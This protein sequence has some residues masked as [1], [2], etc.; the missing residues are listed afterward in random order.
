MLNP[1]YVLRTH[2]NFRDSSGN[3]P[4]KTRS[5]VIYKEIPLNILQI[6]SSVTE[7]WKKSFLQAITFTCNDVR[8]LW[9]ILWSNFLLL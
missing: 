9:S 7:F 2:V 4:F 8:I 5:G 1:A 6:A 3:E